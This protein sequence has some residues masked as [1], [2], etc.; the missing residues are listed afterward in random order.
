M[1]RVSCLHLLAAVFL[2]LAIAAPVSSLYCGSANCYDLLNIKSNATKSEVR[3]AYRRLSVEK[4]PDKRPGDE[5]AAEEFRL[6]GNAYTAL[7][8]D[9]KRAKY[10]DF[11]ANPGKY[12]DFLASNSKEV[13]APKTNIVIAFTL[14]LGAFTLVNWLNLN[15]TYKSTLERMRESQAFKREVARL[16]KSKA[17]ATPDEAEAM[18][19]LEVEGL[20]EP[21]WK[22]LAVVK[23]AGMPARALAYLKW[24]VNWQIA[25]KLM[26][27]DYSETDKQYLIQRNLEISDREWSRMPEV[28]QQALFEKKLWDTTEAAEHSR[29]ERIALNRAGKKKRRQQS[30]GADGEDSLI[31]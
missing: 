1:A 23:L 20:E 10:D 11:L 31:E 17:A 5:A 13:Y 14:I 8:D 22:N 9:M 6:I 24:L 12:W 15:L 4:H 27:K 28:S 7:K 2:L 3:R 21:H 19:N 25:Y 30:S 29:L 16:V 26:K 18:I